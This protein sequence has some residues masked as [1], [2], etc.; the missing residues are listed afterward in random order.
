MNRRRTL[1]PGETALARDVFGAELDCAATRVVHG[2]AYFFQ[3][4][5]VVMAPDGAMYFP[6][7]TYRDDFSVDPSDDVRG[8]FVHELA[9]VLQHQ[10]GIDVRLRGLWIFLRGGYLARN[11]ARTYAADPAADDASL[12]IEQQATRW[13][14][15]YLA[16]TKR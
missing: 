4:D 8:L 10:Q 14:Q 13:E 3:P 15:R 7:R 11:V 5:H 1:T 16:L 2:K 12:N 6:G 9:H